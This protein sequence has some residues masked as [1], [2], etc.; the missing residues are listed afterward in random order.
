MTFIPPDALFLKSGTF[1]AGESALL[2]LRSRTL[3]A[4]ETA[5]L[6][7]PRPPFDCVWRPFLIYELPLAKPQLLL[8]IIKARLHVREKWEILPAPPGATYIEWVQGVWMTNV[9]LNPASAVDGGIPPLHKYP[10]TNLSSP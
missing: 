9:A 8:Y 5:L 1:K 10:G 2:I 7:L 6:I 4:G 3:K